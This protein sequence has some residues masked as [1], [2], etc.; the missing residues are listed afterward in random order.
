MQATLGELRMITCIVITQELVLKRKVIRDRTKEFLNDEM[1]EIERYKWL[2]S[3]KA[4]K[5]LGNSCC[6]QWIE[7]Y[8]K[9]YREMWE[10]E[11]GKIIEEIE[12]EDE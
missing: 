2:Q 1:K 4:K 10:K 7:K 12:V 8:A 6:L 3:E 5:D 9:K 11:N